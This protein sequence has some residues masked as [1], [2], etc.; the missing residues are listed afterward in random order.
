MGK[1]TY[2]QYIAR[3]ADTIYA[4]YD[5]RY[6]A[7]TDKA[8]ATGNLNAFSYLAYY[9]NMESVRYAATGDKQF[10]ARAKRALLDIGAYVDRQ[11]LTGTPVMDK[12]FAPGIYLG[13]YRRVSDSGVF[14]PEDIQT[15]QRYAADTL[16]GYRT[17]PE[18]GAHNRASAR[19]HNLLMGAVCFP[20]HP[21][22]PF[23]KKLSHMLMSDSYGK[24]SIEDAGTYHPIWFNAVLNYAHELGDTAFYNEPAA[25]YYFRYFLDLLCPL[26]VIPDHGDGRWGSCWTFVVSCMEAGAAAFRDGEMKAAAQRIFETMTKLDDGL[27]VLSV[28]GMNGLVDAYLWADDTVEPEAREK[29]SREVLDDLVGKKIV[30]EKDGSYLLTNYRDEGSYG[31]L[32]RNYLR[33]TIPVEAEKAHH[34]HA[35]EGSIVCLVS[36]GCV[37][38]HD[39][40]YRDEISQTAAYRADYYHNRL[41]MRNG[42]PADGVSFFDYIR[43]RGRYLPVVTEK[44][45][46]QRFAGVDASRVRVH[47]TH[48]H[49]VWDRAITFLKEHNVY[50]VVD[51]A[52]AEEDGYY[53]FGTQY[54]TRILTQ[55]A[56]GVW[57][58][59]LD[60]LGSDE[61]LDKI[62]NDT[63]TTLLLCFPDRTLPTGSISL[64][65][66]Y[67][68][69]TGLYQWFSGHL[70]RGER[71]PVVSLLVPDDGGR[72]VQQ[73]ATCCTLSKTDEGVGVQLALDGRQYTL[74]FQ[75]D[76][77]QGVRTGYVRP[78]YNYADNCVHYGN[79]TTDA[80]FCCVR[81]DNA[82]AFVCASEV[83]MGEDVLFCAPPD[84]F[85]NNLFAQ[86]EGRAWWEFWEDRW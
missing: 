35:D 85:L 51:V 58:G 23:W 36:D 65:R 12:L 30:F 55:Q 39:G 25:R 66:S 4:E 31:W 8:T 82:Y 71:V 22:A 44:I 83:T 21:D 11:G 53:T 72:D 15:V 56:E 81:D 6:Q 19:A 48:H 43:D 75:Y 80:L 76:K 29:E 38:L 79:L 26:G 50:V 45:Y 57:R 60:Y 2:L 20:G 24:W 86:N 63:S 49:M 78:T 37:L 74:A 70:R 52:Q 68:D 1:Q 73:V 62:P 7:A 3:V 16:N 5:V 41:V 32:Q 10:A 42:C 18:W 9:A 33:N 84:S 34:G 69:E 27:S 64:R 54:F 77:N 59:T 61:Y 46:F 67:T 17:H 47:D 28:K 13:A 40:G 14:T